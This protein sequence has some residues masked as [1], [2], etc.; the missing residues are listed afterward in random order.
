MSIDNRTV[1]L[2]RPGHDFSVGEP[3]DV[4]CACVDRLA[5]RGVAHPLAVVCAGHAVTGTTR[6]PSVTMFGRPRAIVDAT[7]S[8]QSSPT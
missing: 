5:G 6:S 3:V 2:A 7:E 4:H 1:L 8:Q